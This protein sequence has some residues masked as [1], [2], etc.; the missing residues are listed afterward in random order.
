MRK[1]E[2]D[3]H[4]HNVRR[5]QANKLKR[6]A[7]TSMGTVTHIHTGRTSTSRN[8]G[9]RTHSLCFGFN[10]VL[11]VA[12]LSLTLRAQ[13]HLGLLTQRGRKLLSGTGCA[14]AA[15]PLH[16]NRER[17][18]G[19]VASHRIYT[20]KY[21]VRRKLNQAEKVGGQA[22]AAWCK[23]EMQGSAI[24]WGDVGGV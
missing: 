24:G 12:P 15:Q 4:S 1:A 2:P 21:G 7:Q 14:N 3:E 10:S 23:T 5:A 18:T 11:F 16:K 8:G 6:N 22:S 20:T 19:I 13:I 9:L 17:D